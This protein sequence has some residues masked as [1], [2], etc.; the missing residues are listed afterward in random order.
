MGFKD[1]VTTLDDVFGKHDKGKSLK[2]KKLR[3]LEKALEKKQ[4]KYR[5]LLESGSASE[6]PEQTQTRLQVVNAQLAKLRELM[7][8]DGAKS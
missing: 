2:R 7:G 3:R 5:Q 8:Q 6:T 4:A 1:L